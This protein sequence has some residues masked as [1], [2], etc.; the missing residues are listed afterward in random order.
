MIV[1][2]AP[3]ISL[4]HELRSDVVI[5][6][7]PLPRP[8][9]LVTLFDTHK[10]LG[11]AVPKD[12]DRKRA[13]AHVTGCSWF[14]AEQILY[15]GLKPGK[16]GKPMMDMEE[17]RSLRHGQ[18]EQVRGLSVIRCDATF[19]DVAGNGWV[20]SRLERIFN[21]K[22]PPNGIINIEEINWAMSGARGDN[23]GVSQ[24]QVGAVLDHMETHGDRGIIFFGVP[25]CSKSWIT[26][27]AGSTFGVD[28]L[29][30][31]LNAMKQGEVG[32]SE[33]NIREAL[34]V[35][36]AVTGGNK[37]WIATCNSVAGLDE[38][39]LRRFTYGIVYFDLPTVEEMA[40]VWKVQLRRF[41]V[42]CP[43]AELKKIDT[44][45]W[46][47]ADVRNCCRDADDFTI[48]V[49]DAALETNPAVRQNPG[50]LTRFRRAAHMCYRCA[51]TGEYYMWKD[52]PEGH[53]DEP[54]PEADRAVIV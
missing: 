14:G 50:M 23:T 22:N 4:P 11:A 28:A 17:V 43:A 38:A 54:L 20:K 3:A 15:L 46:T 31:D 36:D 48:S 27:T 18:I 2:L 24:D 52:A 10:A 5:L 8:E 40:G 30:F 33:S 35:G 7:D 47:P 6:D 32:M 39:L 29:K 13:A 51:S 16:G 25:G 42:K 34:K 44:G 45:L 21:G 41:G 37:L 26:Q 12:A 53:K 1:F 49:P 9:Q 19:D